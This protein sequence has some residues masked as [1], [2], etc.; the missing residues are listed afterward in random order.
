MRYEATRLREVAG[1]E[2]MRE[3]ESKG[4]GKIKNRTRKN[5]YDFYISN[6]F[7]I[8]NRPINIFC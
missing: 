3:E 8:R 1:M 6:G 5:R 4:E 2:L 7:P